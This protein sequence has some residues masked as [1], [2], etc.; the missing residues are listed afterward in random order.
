M[1]QKVRKLL[2]RIADLLM[3]REKLLVSVLKEQAGFLI[4]SLEMLS[5]AV[6]AFVES[7]DV[8][9]LSLVL[10]GVEKEADGLLLEINRLIERASIAPGLHEPLLRLTEKVDDV[11]DSARVAAR[12]MSRMQCR[13]PLEVPKG[14]AKNLLILRQLAVEAA[15][16]YRC[17]LDN[18]LSDA[19]NFEECVAVVEAL[20]EKGDDVKEAARD[21][22]YGE[23][24]DR[25][26]WEVVTLERLIFILDKILDSL[27]DACDELILLRTRVLA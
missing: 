8:G 7:S 6:E 20:E 2:S 5:N 22:L 3:P 19:Y 16:G 27:E 11:I 9:P 24:G 12:E 4:G 25:A 13:G 15:R 18:L 14:V 21:A 17:A 1:S 26:W 23:A 10:D